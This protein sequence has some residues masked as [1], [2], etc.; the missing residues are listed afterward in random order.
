MKGDQ[1]SH[2][3]KIQRFHTQRYELRCTCIEPTIE[4]RRP[5]KAKTY[6]RPKLCAQLHWSIWLNW[7]NGSGQDPSSPPSPSLISSEAHR[8]R[9]NPQST[10]IESAK[11][12]RV[13]RSRDGRGLSPWP[14]SSPAPRRP[15]SAG[16]M[17]RGGRL[18]GEQKYRNTGPHAHSRAHARLPW[19]CERCEQGGP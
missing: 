10:P 1:R 5:K 11:H 3:Q 18:R 4:P 13:R 16:C 15:P 6:K 8:T 17:F 19:V 12:V 7:S 14:S 2:T 9:P